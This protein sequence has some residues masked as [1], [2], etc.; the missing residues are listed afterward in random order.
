MKIAVPTHRR[1]SVIQNLTL[2]VLNGISKDSIYIFI[3]DEADMQLYKESCLGYN[4]ILCHTKTATEKFNFIQNYFEEGTFVIVIEDD[5]KKI[6]S[7][8]TDDAQ[9]IFNFIENYC[10]N[11]R[12]N[13]FGVYPSS[14]KFFM[15]KTIETGFTYLVA[16][17][18]GFRAAKSPELLCRMSS[19]TDYERSVLFY[20]YY[21]EL[22]R[23]NFIACST[24]NYTNK[25]GMQEEKNR[26]VLE[27]QSSQMLVRLYPEYFAINHKRKSKYLE[28]KVN[29][30]VIQEKI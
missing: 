5:I 26:D 24:N 25:G 6:Q 20:K 30:N 8:V 16:N 27:N 14:N 12:I 4:L 17:L 10:V 2:S 9:K 15:K 1:S 11:K 19:K 28:L 22:V 23:F 21:G 13:A 3:S 18:F 7:L 29:K